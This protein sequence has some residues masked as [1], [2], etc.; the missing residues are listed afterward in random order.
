[1]KFTFKQ[2]HLSATNDVVTKTPAPAVTAR[3]SLP[4]D[5][6]FNPPRSC[7]G[8]CLDSGTIECKPPKFSEPGVYSVS[9]SMDGL[10]FLRD[11]VEIFVHQELVVQKQAPELLDL[12][13]SATV[14]H[15]EL[16]RQMNYIF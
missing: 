9:I 16:V 15:L 13:A 7:S 5:P 8:Q 6:G 10:T 2:A 11:T 4:G 12:S 1:M 14:E 3:S